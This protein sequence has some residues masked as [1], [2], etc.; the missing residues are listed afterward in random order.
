M[1]RWYSI[2]SDSSSLNRS[3]PC[4]HE[5]LERI[6]LLKIIYFFWW[7]GKQSVW[8][9]TDRAHSPLL[10]PKA[11][12]N[13]FNQDHKVLLSIPLKHL[14]QPLCTCSLSYRFFLGVRN[15]LSRYQYIFPDTKLLYLFQAQYPTAISTPPSRTE[16]CIPK[17]TSS[18]SFSQA[19]QVS[20]TPKLF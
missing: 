8:F 11:C 19:H 20:S 6:Y 18:V 17:P 9:A 16:A 14:C 5:G 10:H 12:M 15:P 7:C 2:G 3:G 13:A 1:W 4:A